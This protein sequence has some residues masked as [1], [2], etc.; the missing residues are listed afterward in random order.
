MFNTIIKNTKLYKDL[1]NKNKYLL[2]DRNILEEAANTLNRERVTLGN[3]LATARK[4]IDKL[5]AAGGRMV[6]ENS[7]VL[8]EFDNE[9]AVTVK[10]RINSDI[11]MKLIDQEYITTEFAEDEA[12]IQFAFILMANEASEQII[13]G[14]NSDED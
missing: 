11:V 10:S 2:M 7:S 4:E 14:V 13:L 12:S 8:F 1:D 6:D 9:L 3:E 5:K